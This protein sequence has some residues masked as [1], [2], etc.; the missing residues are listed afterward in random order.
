MVFLDVDGVLA[1]YRSQVYN[2]AKDGMQEDSGLIY[3]HHLCPPK[4]IG[5]SPLEESCVDNLKWL[6]SRNPNTRVVLS[7]TWRL[8]PHLKSFLVDTLSAK[9]IAVLGQTDDLFPQS[10]GAEVRAWL[11]KHKEEEGG[12]RWPATLC[13]TMTRSTVMLATQSSPLAMLSR[14]SWALAPTPTSTQRQVSRLHL[15]GWLWSP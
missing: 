2:A 6:V 15:H 3:G 14:P 13:W 9:G 5:R 12:M 10:R 4:S 1:C 7:T 11:R 8:Q